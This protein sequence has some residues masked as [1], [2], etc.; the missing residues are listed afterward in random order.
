MDNHLAKIEKG[1]KQMLEMINSLMAKSKNDTTE[2]LAI[3]DINE[4]LQKEIEFLNAD[5]IFKYKI[6]KSINFFPTPLLIKILP[7]ELSQIFQNLV[8]NAMDAM[9]SGEGRQITITTDI[10]GEDIWFSIKDNGPGISQ[11][12]QQKIFDPFFSTKLRA[13]KNTDDE[14]TG[15]GLGL[16]MC[17]QMVE[18]YE[19]RIELIS[20][21]GEGAEFKVVLPK[22]E[23]EEELLV[24]S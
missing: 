11:E 9:Y 14:P 3:V 13:D 5:P 16:H 20:K 21:E 24:V 2:E 19:G 4:L 8:R 7:G 10:S 17:S 1:T 6:E 15:T 22:K 18:K 12:N 23:I